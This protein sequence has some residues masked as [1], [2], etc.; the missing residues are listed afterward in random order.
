MSTPNGLFKGRFKDFNGTI[1]FIM[2]YMS[3]CSFNFGY[4]VGNFSG[5]QGMQSFGKK[6]GEYDA[7]TGLWS[8]PAWLSS[9]MTSVPFFGKA[10]T[11]ATTAAQFT[12]GR[13]IAFAMTGFTIIIVPIYQAEIAPK[14]V[15]G[16]LNST[17]QMMIIFG[18]VVAALVVLGTKNMEGDAGWRIPVGLQFVAPALILAFYPLVPESPRWL[19]SQ[20]RVDEATKQ[21]KR[22]RKESSDEQIST[23]IETLRMS[24]SNETKGTWKEVFNKENRVRTAVAVLAMFGQQATGQAFISQY[25][26]IF[27]QSQGFAKQAFVFN[28]ISPCLGIV[29]LLLTWFIVDAV[30][31]RPL[32]LIGSTLMAIFLCVVGSVS[33]VPNPTQ[34]AK[35]AMVASFMLFGCSFNL[36]WGP[37]SFVVVAEA[38]ASRVKEKTNLLAGVISVITTF[39]TSFT[40]PY[41]INKRYAGLGG[42]IG[43]IYGGICVVM[44]ILTWFFV[45]ELKGRSLEEIDELF[46]SAA[47]LRKFGDV[48]TTLGEELYAGTKED[49]VDAEKQDAI[50]VT[51]QD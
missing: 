50:R 25:N 13:V 26:V 4:D 22:L 12:V 23:E 34:A 32:L 33:T 29:C 43:F 2:F 1:L 9:L 21:L 42:K 27:Y 11:T 41:L 19:L 40:I 16:M 17:L 15:R 18:Q 46:A 39:V 6:F 24:S 30:G 47:P 51:Q 3:S 45:P 48:Q 49:S 7:Q 5:V 38:A 35:E 20:N 36:S 31:R 14:S 37:V 10:A 28:L 44:L 8:L